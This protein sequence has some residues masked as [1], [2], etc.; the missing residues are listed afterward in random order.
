MNVNLT[1][2]IQ[3]L[4]FVGFIML[5]MQ[6]AWPVFEKV[7]DERAATIAKGLEDAER[8]RHHLHEADETVKALLNDARKSARQAIED[9]RNQAEMII[10][11]A[12][13]A[14][15]VKHDQIIEEAY[16]DIEVQRNKLKED[17]IEEVGGLA[18]D[19]AK[20]LLDKVVD[21]KLD[22]KIIEAEVKE[23]VDAV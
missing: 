20:R 9:A 3:V 21:V 14:A 13:E 4:I 18:V 22:K 8:A 5:I 16:A 6:Y 7:L 17:L 12:R 19:V 2:L 15:E 23:V 10:K 11:E 1:L